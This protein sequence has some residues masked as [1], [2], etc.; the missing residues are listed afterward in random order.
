MPNEKYLDH[1]GLQYYHEKLQLEL[2]NLEIT[3]DNLADIFLNELGIPPTLPENWTVSSDGT[4][5]VSLSNAYSYWP[6]GAGTKTIS[7]VNGTTAGLSKFFLKLTD[8]GNFPMQWGSNIQWKNGSEPEWQAFYEDI[9]L[10]TSKDNGNTWTAQ[11]LQTN[12]ITPYWKITVQTTSNNESV[13]IP[14]EC[15]YIKTI[16]W[17]DGNTDDYEYSYIAGISENNYDVPGYSP[18]HTYAT[19]G[20]HK[21][22]IIS[23]VFTSCYI[24]NWDSCDYGE[25]R[26][27]KKLI[28]IDS[29]LPALRGTYTWPS[30]YAVATDNSFEYI[31]TVCEQLV[32]IPE[33]LFYNNPSCNTFYCAFEKCS[34]LQSI[35][36][37][38][39][40]KNTLVTTFE[41]CFRQCSSL[42]SIPAGLFDKN[43]TVT[44]FYS[45]FS[46]CTSLTNFKLI[47]GSSL[48]KN[49]SN[50]ISNASNVTRIL[51]VPSNS[52]TYNT[53]TSYAN[54]SNGITVST[55]ETDCIE[56]FEYTVQT[57]LSEF[58]D[59]SWDDDYSPLV[60][61]V[62]I[63]PVQNASASLTIDWGD[64][65]AV[66]LQPSSV[67]E[68]NL[69]HTYATAGTYQITVLSSNWSDYKFMAVDFVDGSDPSSSDPVI[70]TFRDKLVSLDAPMPPVANTDLIYWFQYCQHLTTI[71]SH[72]F[73]NLPNV[74]S[75]K[76]CFARCESLTTV[77]EGLFAKNT[78]ITSFSECFKNCFGLQTI[79]AGLFANNTAAADFSSCFDWNKVLQSIPAGL[80][81]NNTA[82]TNF[83]YCFGD[84]YAIQTIPENLFASNTIVTNFYGC[85]YD[86]NSLG[87]FT[88][89]IGSSLV[90]YADN[91]VKSKSG[92]TRIV[93]VPSG[94]TTQTTFNNYASSLRL[95]VR[96]E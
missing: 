34:S 52:T 3:D 23:E 37:G 49:F 27:Y 57:D 60:A 38:L 84:C 33:K 21:I 30:S 94:S 82:A 42:Q 76:G 1:A 56:V 41:G 95:T 73:D 54:S 47:I 71:N 68:A 85:F 5:D 66:E 58:D 65:N 28:S 4:L 12:E 96:G 75:A 31:F 87:G 39:F 61:A 55:V 13:I 53:A 67:V 36:A 16:D 83:R 90:A 91:F 9:V 14:F 22:K 6:E 26:Y 20:Y 59:P 46:E 89:H 43:T 79:P 40:D 63:E 45:T 32:S 24:Q 2:D 86:C 11:V 18:Q 72:L 48:V 64:G 10:F 77:P 7:I 51:C 62:P 80:F 50:F 74:T 35:P 44:I 69:I 81:A 93:Y 17:G 29:P 70:Q 15:E 78:A 92:T 8:A 25:E 88:I 19:I